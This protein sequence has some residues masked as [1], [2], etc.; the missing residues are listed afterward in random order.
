MVNLYKK[1]KK[2]LYL[3]SLLRLR[4]PPSR[5]EVP[6]PPISRLPP[7]H[8]PLPSSLLQPPFRRPRPPPH[9]PNATTIF[10]CLSKHF[11]GHCVGI[12]GVQNRPLPSPAPLP[13]SRPLSLSP[14]PSFSVTLVKIHITL[15][16]RGYGSA[17]TSLPPCPLQAVDF[18]PL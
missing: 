5:R 3:V 16:N 7:S 12:P 2:L 18:V 15:C 13:W 11:H 4:L 8:P 9:P 14:F 17:P 1:K 10:L 6:H